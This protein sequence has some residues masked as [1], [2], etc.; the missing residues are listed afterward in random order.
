MTQQALSKARN[1]FDHTPFQKIFCAVRDA[2]YGEENI[3]DMKRFMG[4]FL[5]A[6]DGSETALPNLPQLCK[7]FGGTGR[8]ASLSNSQN[9]HC[10]RCGK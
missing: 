2:A 1:H 10:L 9:E 5:V 6:V 8:C 7:E 3:A 4:L